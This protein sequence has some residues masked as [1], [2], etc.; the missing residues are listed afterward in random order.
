MKRL[1]KKAKVK[2]KKE[3]VKMEKQKGGYMSQSDES[4]HPASP[5]ATPWQAGEQ[6]EDKRA[7]L[8]SAGAVSAQVSSELT[9]MLSNG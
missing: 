8:D 4:A 1:H 7:G 9:R 3:K 2:S 6:A 5:G